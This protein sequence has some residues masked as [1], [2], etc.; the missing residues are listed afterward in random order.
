MRLYSQFNKL[1]GFT[2]IELL[3]VIAI[4]GVLAAATLVAVNPIEQINRAKDSSRKEAISQ[5]G[6]AVQSYNSL[7][8]AFPVASTTW[9]NDLIS[10]G[11]IKSVPDNGAGSTYNPVC[12]TGA[13][14]AFNHGGFCYKTATYNNPITGL[15]STEAIIY[16]I[17]E[18]QTD[19]AKCRTATDPGKPYYLWGSIEGRA[20]VVCTTSTGFPAVGVQTFR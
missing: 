9:I 7:R 18:S 17:L 2:L 16:A 4:L 1:P 14:A 6:R 11:E 12:E 8:G 10:S 5:L 3:I 13:G 15:Q 19:R 20:G